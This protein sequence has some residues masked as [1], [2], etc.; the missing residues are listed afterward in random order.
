VQIDVNDTVLIVVGS[1]L[2]PEE[3]DR[4]LAYTLKRTIDAQGRN[5]YQRA[6][7]VS[8]R[9][10]LENEIFQTCP[11]IIVG[12][13]GVNAAAAHFY[14]KIP[15]VWTSSEKGDAFVQVSLGDS[16]ACAALWGMNQQAT[17]AA[18]DAFV[19]QGFLQN[20]LSLAWKR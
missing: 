11:S 9:W 14:K 5:A 20:M 15:V 10:Y 13:P 18:M 19:D 12:G 3:K 17:S 1:E 2:V 16:A 6:I 7:V 4:P 8:D